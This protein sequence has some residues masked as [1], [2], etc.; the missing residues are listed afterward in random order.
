[1]PEL[2]AHAPVF[3]EEGVGFEDLFA[4]G[5]SFLKSMFS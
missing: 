2:A 3:G 1:L 4:H 5:W